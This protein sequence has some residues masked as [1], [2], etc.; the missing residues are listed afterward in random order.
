M[1]QQIKFEEATEKF[2]DL[3]KNDKE[4]IG[5][6]IAGSFV[7]SELDK[8]S[9]VDIHLILDEN[10]DYRE[11]GNTWIDGV[12]IEYFK[13]PPKQIRSYFK[14]ETECPSTANMFVDSI[15]KY[16]SS[17]IIDDLIEEAKQI[18]KIK[19][20]SLSKN[21]KEILK[22]GINDLYKDLEDCLDKNDR[23]GFHFVKNEIIDECISIFLKLN[24]Q[25][26][27]KE[28]NLFALLGKIDSNF[29]K[30]VENT[31][32]EH[33]LQ[34]KQ[35]KELVEYTENLLGGRRNKEWIL[36]TNLDL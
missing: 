4:I 28:K 27:V 36:R 25:Y 30:L 19:S 2:L 6:L 12:E 24:R 31:L 7:R 5:I 33:L 35:I 21:E 32:T 13:N 23:T 15:V 10:C 8:N 20:E 3:I 17:E 9:D 14:K 34:M 22:Y 16:K 1:N 26:R 29:S 11:R 18:I